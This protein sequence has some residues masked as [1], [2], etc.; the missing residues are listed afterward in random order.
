MD[1][2]TAAFGC[3]YPTDHITH[4]IPTL[5]SVFP[6]R[7]STTDVFGAARFMTTGTTGDPTSLLC[8]QPYLNDDSHG[9]GGH[10]PGDTVNGKTCKK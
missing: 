7:G 5:R 6:P 2:Q 3:S 8:A 10:W 9:Q 1:G 4:D